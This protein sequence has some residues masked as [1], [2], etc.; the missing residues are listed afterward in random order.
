VQQ[1][2]EASTEQLSTVASKTAYM[3]ASLAKVQGSV[4]EMKNLK[5]DLLTRLQALESPK[6]DRIGALEQ[7]ARGQAKQVQVTSPIPG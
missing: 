7:A 6:V 3:E 5:H 2:V 4:G 1:N